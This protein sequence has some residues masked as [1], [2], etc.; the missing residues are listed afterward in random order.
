MER[1][2]KDGFS[3]LTRILPT[4]IA[5]LLVFFVAAGNFQ[6]IEGWIYFGLY[7]LINVI[8]TIFLFISNRDLINR[9][10]ANK[11]DAKSKDHVYLFVYILSTRFLAPLIAGLEI[12]I[13]QIQYLNIYV[14]ITGILLIMFSSY[15]ENISMY[16]NSFFERN[17][18]IQ[19]DQNQMVISN[20][21]YKIIRHPGYLSYI[22][23]FIA[24]PMIIGTIISSV[25]IFV[26][27]FTIVLRTNYEDKTLSNE[28][29]GYDE[30]KMKT[31][32]RLIPLIW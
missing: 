26:G 6:N 29:D 15:L 30:Y 23:R 12:R 21:P 10:G 11:T 3:Y 16:Y 4:E 31:K 8:N 5:P 28:L 22:L 2:T 24:F 13:F 25:V 19:K 9:R 1:L 18:R 27:I 32:Y 20:G 14:V 7:V 17:I